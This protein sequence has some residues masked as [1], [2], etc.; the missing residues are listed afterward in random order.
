MRFINNLEEGQMAA[1]QQQDIS[2]N[3][4]QL[5]IAFVIS[6]AIV[7]G[8]IAYITNTLVNSKVNAID[9]VNNPV[10]SNS[11]PQTNSATVG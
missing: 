8:F 2:I 11:A 1:K 9:T 6:M 5:I 10:T 7:C 4:N 3:I